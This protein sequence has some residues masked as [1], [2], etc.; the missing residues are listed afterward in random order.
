MTRAQQLL[1]VIG[2]GVL[3]WIVQ[4]VLPNLLAPIIQANYTRAVSFLVILAVLW[5]GLHLTLRLAARRARS[6]LEVEQR[7][8]VEARR[9]LIVF[10]SPG[11]R[12]TPAEN[13]IKAH[14]A[15]LEHCWIIVGPALPGRGPSARD[16][17]NRIAQEY[18]SQKPGLKFYIQDLD[19]EHDPEKTFRLVR[20]IYDQARTLGL[21]EKEIIADYTGGTKSMTAGM[22]LACSTSP[23]RDAQYMK[24]KDVTGTG[25][26]TPSAEA[27]PVLIDLNFGPRS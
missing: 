18:A 14:L 21:S 19:D 5:G 1:S 22:V 8:Q 10:S 16:N 24:A 17:A 23:D 7:S 3:T 27:T 25:V 9:G 11:E 2:I 26:A 20:S 12:V 13:A 6:R 15:K 4:G